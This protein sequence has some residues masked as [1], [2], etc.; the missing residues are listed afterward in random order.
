[1]IVEPTKFIPLFFRSLEILSDS[2]VL[3]GMSWW[4]L[5]LFFIGLFLMNAQMYLSKLPNSFLISMKIL[6]FRIADFIFNL[7]LMIPA[8]FNSSF[9]FA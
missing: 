2:S 1:M 5:G 8:L 3:A 6:A 9:S 7:F 4:L